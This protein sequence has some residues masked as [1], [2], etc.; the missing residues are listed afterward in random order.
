MVGALLLCALILYC[1]YLRFCGASAL[2]EA[3]GGGGGGN[4]AAAPEPTPKPSGVG[5]KTTQMVKTAS[6]DVPAPPPKGRSRSPWEQVFDEA[7]GESCKWRQKVQ[8]PRFSALSLLVFHLGIIVMVLPHTAG[9]HPVARCG[10][11]DCGGCGCASLPRHAT[12][13]Q[14]RQSSKRLSPIVPPVA[15]CSPACTRTYYSQIGGTATQ[16]RRRGIG[17]VAPVMG[18]PQWSKARDKTRV[19]RSIGHRREK[20]NVRNCTGP[21]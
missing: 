7:S 20:R 14:R 16:T 6:R 10:G 15:R 19:M 2:A 21:Y 18:E 11:G 5:G 9:S 4:S 3:R 1:A 8:R 17:P 12:K 13:P